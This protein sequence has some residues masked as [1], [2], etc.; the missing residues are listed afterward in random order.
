[1]PMARL[2]RNPNLVDGFPNI[3]Q[4]HV[5]FRIA[6]ALRCSFFVVQNC[7]YF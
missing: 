2:W 6:D 4:L 3:P 1:M 5:P 7:V